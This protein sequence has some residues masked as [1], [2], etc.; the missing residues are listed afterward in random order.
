MKKCVLIPIEKYNRFQI[1]D[2]ELDKTIW[3]IL[4]DSELNQNDKL[5][6]YSDIIYQWKQKTTEDDN[7]EENKDSVDK[8]E[9]QKKDEVESGLLIDED[10][11]P[12]VVDDGVDK[13]IFPHQRIRRKRKKQKISKWTFY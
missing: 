12:N 8:S 2:T 6:A 13:M 3:D 7:N 9:K 10:D 4:R 1:P 11:K 5:K